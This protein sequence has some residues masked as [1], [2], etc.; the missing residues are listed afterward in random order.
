MSKPTAVRPERNYSRCRGLNEWRYDG[1]TYSRIVDKPFSVMRDDI[2][3]K[4]A[5][6]NAV[7]KDFAPESLIDAIRK[8]IRR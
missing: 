1:E 2:R 7:E 5:I 3:L 8:G 6:K 4:R